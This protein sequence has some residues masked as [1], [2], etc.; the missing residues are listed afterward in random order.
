MG[1][2]AVGPSH[3]PDDRSTRLAVPENVQADLQPQPS[4]IAGLVSDGLLEPCPQGHQSKVPERLCL[5]LPSRP[6]RRV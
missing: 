1:V 2:Q 3:Q 6:A 4:R 5:R